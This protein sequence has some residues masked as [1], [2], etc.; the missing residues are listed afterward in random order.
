MHDQSPLQK[1]HPPF[2]FAELLCSLLQ[3]GPR[4]L[5]VVWLDDTLLNC[6][7]ATAT[8]G[9]IPVLFPLTQPYIDHDPC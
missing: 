2:D 9:Y 5:E 6:M 8:T 4:T 3:G 1:V 7:H